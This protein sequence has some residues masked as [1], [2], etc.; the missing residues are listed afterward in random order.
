MLK[1][2]PKRKRTHAHNGSDTTESET[3]TQTRRPSELARGQ[4][5][6]HHAKKTNTTNSVQTD[7]QEHE[8]DKEEERA[9][10]SGVPT[11]FGHLNTS[12]V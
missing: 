5:L 9:G 6:D 8:E 1:A 2:L 3:C 11:R 10:H 7:G 12:R 4:R